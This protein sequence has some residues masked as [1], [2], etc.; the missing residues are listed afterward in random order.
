MTSPAQERTPRLWLVEQYGHGGIGRYAVDV[1]NLVGPAGDTVVATTDGGPVGG[2]TGRSVVWFPRGS[3]SPVAKARAAATGLLRAARSVRRGD[4]AWVPLG[5]RPGYERLLVEALRRG[6][7]RVVA[8]VHNRAPHGSSGSSATVLASARRAHAVVVH[9][10][11]MADWAAEHGLP[12][13]RLPFPPPDIAPGAVALGP[14]EARRVRDELG[15]PGGAVLVAFLGYLYP[16]KGPDVL[17]T[18]L[19]EARRDRPDLAVHVLMAG[20]PSPEQDLPELVRRLGIGSAVT[21]QPGWLEES[22]MAELLS[23]ADVLALPYRRIDNSGMAALG[24]RWQLP[25]V[26][27][28]LPLLRDTYGDAAVFVRP[29]DP[30][31]LA[32][33]LTELPGRLTALR[34]AAGRMGAEDLETPYR[35]F[36]RDALAGS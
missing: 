9:T 36:V 15:V 32:R 1:A 5:I 16:Y 7:A 3:D 6:G 29:D 28:E 13:V 26:A 10:D 23:A 27:S 20:R 19:A 11:A 2:L 33:A 30:A 18:A 24:R 25:A 31:D 8:T 14:V 34:D 22:R 35:A 12:A 17:L 4:V 21:L